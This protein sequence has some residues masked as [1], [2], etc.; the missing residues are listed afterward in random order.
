MSKHSENPAFA[1][2]KLFVLLMTC[3]LFICAANGDVIKD[4]FIVNDSIPPNQGESSVA[5]NNSGNFVIVWRDWR[6]GPTYGE[7]FAQRYNSSGVPQG[8]EFSV[9]TDI[10]TYM[11]PDIAMDNS[12]NFCIVWTS[13]TGI[14]AQR[15]LANGNPNGSVITVQGSTNSPRYPSIAMDADGDF[16][17]CWQQQEGGTPVRYDLY[18]RRYNSSGNPQGSAFQVNTDGVGSNQY[19]SA[20]AIADDSRFCIT[21]EDRRTVTADVYARIYN[22]SG[23]PAGDDFKIN[24]TATQYTWPGPSVAMAGNGDFIITWTDNRTGT[25][26][27]MAQKY[28]SAGDTIHSNFKVGN[29]YEVWMVEGSRH[30]VACNASLIAFSWIDGRGGRDTYGKL[31]DWDYG[32]VGTEEYTDNINQVVGISVYPNPFRTSLVIKYG[33]ST[34]DYA[35]RNKKVPTVRIY[36]VSGRL[37]KQF[38]HLTMRQSD[39]VIWDGRDNSGTK[40]QDGVYFIKMTNVVGQGFPEP[41]QVNLTKKVAVIR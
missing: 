25:I 40:V 20:I 16:C 8:A 13:L 9:T 14:K 41:G 5:M 33:P 28:T 21:W 30:V 36:D 31:V 2:K 35:E 10:S 23:N 7:T 11:M 4:D 39:Q 22:S 6:A 34:N 3:G 27:L 17:I 32:G 24:N 19:N 29:D 1:G 26:H 37:I 18:A 15:Y 38:D 12:G